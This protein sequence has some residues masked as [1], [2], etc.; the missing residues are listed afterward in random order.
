ML[1]D[2]RG[3]AF[4]AGFMLLFILILVAA[5]LADY[6]RLETVRDAAERAAYEAAL[7][8]AS[9][10]RDWD[11][12]ASTG[13]M[14]LDESVAEAEADAYLADAMQGLG[15][16]NYTVDIR[17]LPETDGGTIEGYPPVTRTAAFDEVDWTAIKPAVGVYVEFPV[18]TMLLGLVAGDQVELHVFGAAEAQT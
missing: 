12:A 7:R 16:V 1:S 9:R 17:V 10:G 6:Y 15:Q 2:N 13:S 11:Y 18:E 4:V 3:Q 5:G 14:R 8:G